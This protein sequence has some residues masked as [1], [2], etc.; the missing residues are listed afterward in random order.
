MLIGGLSSASDSGR[1][2][3]GFGIE[4]SSTLRYL[5]EF[6]PFPADVGLDA[7]ARPA[8][9]LWL[10][11]LDE[12]GA[13]FDKL[14]DDDVALFGGLGCEGALGGGLGLIV[15]LRPV[16]LHQSRNPGVVWRKS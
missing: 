1:R 5:E 4:G 2:G 14:D 12:V 6:M 13:E 16:R 8:F 11:G 10:F 15:P 7:G 9:V 3:G